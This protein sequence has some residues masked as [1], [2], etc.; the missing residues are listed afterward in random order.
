MK[1]NNSKIYDYYYRDNGKNK[2]RLNIIYEKISTGEALSTEEKMLLSRLNEIEKI[3]KNR[4]KFF[5]LKQ[6]RRK[7]IQLTSD[8]LEFLN[9]YIAEEVITNLSYQELYFIYIQNY[10]LVI[11]NNFNE[12]NIITRIV[13]KDKFV[14][15]NDLAKLFNITVD[16]ISIFDEKDFGS[17]LHYGNIEINRS[18][19][20][21]K[22]FS[23]TLYGDL[24]VDNVSHAKYVHF[25]K[26]IYGDLI[27]GSLEESEKNYFPNLVYG[28]VDLRSLKIIDTKLPKYVYGLIDVR[29]LDE[30]KYLNHKPEIAFQYATK[31]KSKTR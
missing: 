12:N 14:I 1:I 21:G 8:E 7:R 2:N 30:D 25:P 23:N 3:C 9:D 16:D 11:N 10:D 17:K 31:E 6:K 28:S 19:I 20:N 29:S 13:G 24:I 22:H 15:K 4:D 18:Y 27:L 5:E 26:N